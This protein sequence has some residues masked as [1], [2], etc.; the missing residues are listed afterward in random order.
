[1][2][3]T[4]F[5]PLALLHVVVGAGMTL[6][7]LLA[8]PADGDPIVF[9]KIADQ[10]AKGLVAYRDFPIEYPPLGF[11]AIDLPRLLS[12][13]SVLKYELLFA[14]FSVLF[15]L[16]TGAAVLWLARRRWSSETPAN[17]VL[18]FTG[19][20][21]AGAPLVYWRFDIFAAFLT[22]L[23]LVAYAYGR[24]T[25][26]GLALGFGVVSKIY[27]GALVPVLALAQLFERHVRWAALIVVGA[28]VAS[29]AV[30]TETFLAAG[31][32]AFSFL[33]YQQDRG[34]E[35]ESVSGGIAL[36]ASVLGQ[37]KA[38]ISFGFG[39]Y[40]VSSPIIDSL[41]LPQLALNAV[42]V[43]SLLAALFVSFRRDARNGGTIRPATL[44]RY[45]LATLLVVILVNKVLSP[46]Y[47]VWLL[48]FAALLPSRQS[49]LLLVIV[50]LTVL[51]YPLGFGALV[52]V[53]APAVIALNARNLLLVVY[54]VLVAWPRPAAESERGYVRQPAE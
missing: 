2:R 6:L 21:L 20:A 49:L 37:A 10:S 3:Q 44:L 40:Q 22:A 4:R 5:S 28:A 17:A 46:Q 24:P 41:G 38:A 15:T 29:L 36:L 43:V 35:I 19:L 47:L 25:W 51:L 54:F 14:A 33:A 8:Q 13:P 26:S 52:S 7:V 12:G 11:V 1:V 50:V 27:P 42:L 53:Q 16:G 9:M 34:V 31:N 23:S 48:P 32:G 30:M 39:S 45:S 18:L